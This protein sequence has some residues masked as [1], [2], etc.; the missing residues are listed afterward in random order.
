MGYEIKL[1][2]FSG[3]FDLL[4]YLIETAELDICAISLAQVVD[5]YV[6]YVTWAEK[7]TDLDAVG[8][9][10]ILAARLLLLKTRVLLPSSHLVESEQEELA[11]DQDTEQLVQHLRQYRLFRDLGRELGKMMEK[12]AAFTGIKPVRSEDAQPLLVAEVP[13]PDLDAVVSAWIRL[14]PLFA[15]LRSV[16]VIPERPTVEEEMAD[17]KAYLKGGRT[18]SFSRYLG[19]KP[20]RPRL[21]TVF[22]ALLELWR[23][24]K[25]RVRQTVRFGDIFVARKEDPACRSNH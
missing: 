7:Q 23:Q 17:L 21:V 25:I 5:Q 24:G 2:N 19:N 6:S 12:E 11:V 22:L 15:E 18:L 16:T 20:S 9:F 4:C 1:G 13:P 8:E 3:P 14:K 10:L